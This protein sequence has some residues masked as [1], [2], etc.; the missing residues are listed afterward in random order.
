MK[1][2]CTFTLKLQTPLLGSRWGN[3]CFAKRF[4]SSARMLWRSLAKRQGVC[5][6]CVPFSCALATS[7]G[8]RCAGA[9]RNREHVARVVFLGT[10]PISSSTTSWTIPCSTA[11]RTTRTSRRSR[12]RSPHLQLGLG[13]RRKTRMTQGLT[14]SWKL[15]RK[16]RSPVTRLKP[17]WSNDV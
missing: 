3:L 8:R 10:I 17:G 16:G 13:Q 9:A 2:E 12:S 4:L 5:A 6:V 15:S 1:S 7:K 11:R 14:H